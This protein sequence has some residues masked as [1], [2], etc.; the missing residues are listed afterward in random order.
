MPSAHDKLL[1]VSNL[2]EFRDF[3]MWS[4]HLILHTSQ[5]LKKFIKLAGGKK[6]NIKFY[7]RYNLANHFGW[8]ID[9]LPGGH[10]F[11]NIPNNLNRLYQNYLSKIKKLIL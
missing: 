9:R 6:I 4:E 10:D 11:N 2:K 7:Q 3:T 5:S 8:L 1:T